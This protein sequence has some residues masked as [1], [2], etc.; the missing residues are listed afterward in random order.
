VVQEDAR[1]IS[2]NKF[3]NFT[4][5]TYLCV[6]SCEMPKIVD[7]I[8]KKYGLL[9]V[10]SFAGLTP[11]G[12]KTYNCICDCG[13][14]AVRTGTSIR[15]SENSSCG[16]F[17]KK[18]VAHH[19]WTGVGE[20][21]GDFWYTHIVRSANGSKNG[22]QVRKPKELTLTI[23]QAWNLFIKQDKKCALSGKELTFPKVSKD[24]SWTASLD[25]ID[26]SK[27]YVPGNV[28]WVHKDINIMKNKFDNDY[29]I[30]ICKSVAEKS[31]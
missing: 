14:H 30:H 18:G 31:V 1:L 7:P 25:R 24:K 28:Q 3:G 29:F 8:G 20:I 22:N 11:C 21:S 17:S 13:N 12:H 9:T 2:K 19:Q 23:Q 16:C 6:N 26:S 15:R 27:G 4:T 10:E 5:I